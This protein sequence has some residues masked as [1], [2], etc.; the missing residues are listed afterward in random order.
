MVIDAVCFFN[1]LD[2]LELRLN[3]L[4]PV[5]DRF[6]IVEANRT[7][8][9]T[10]KPLYYA[11]NKARFAEWEEKITHI[12]CPLPDDGDGLPA[13]RRRE[14]MQRNAILQGVRDC[15]DTDVILISDCDEIPR[16]HLIPMVAP[17]VADGMVL[18]FIQK[19]YY[20]NLN[21]HA[22]ARPW[23]GTRMCRVADARAL[24]PHIIRNS[25]GQFDAHYPID[26]HVMDGG[27]HYSYLGDTAHIQNKMREFLHQ[28]LV[29]DENTTPE[30]IEA[31][32]A[33]GLD[34]W[35][36]EGEQEFTIGRADDLPYT[37]LRDLPKWTKH[38]APA[39]APVFHEDWYNGGQA[40]Y[41]GQ[42][43]RTAPEGACVEIGCWEGRSSVILAQMI[44][45]RVLHCV[46]HWRGNVD[47]DEGHES[48]VIAS[49]RD[50]LE[51]F[52]NNMERCTAGNW[53]HYV[54]SWQQFTTQLLMDYEHGDPFRIAFL[55][56]DASHDRK[57]VADCLSA[58]KPFL[59]GGAILCGDDAYDE[60]VIAG[61]RDVF[62]D[63]EVI[64]ERLWK[65]VYV[66]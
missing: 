6:V 1:E 13:I 18:A 32:I 47:E 35:G 65:V 26:R 49:E 63:A 12:I 34:I 2:L 4:A 5:V 51:T 48:A 14:M 8:K 30:A 42:L 43:A 45:P 10:L 7:H 37:I 15:A 44:N 20:F 39:W 60:R 38:F 22:A 64:G 41:V 40:L 16:S 3:E 36:R 58:I 29:T 21:T 24:S 52:V 19:L 59:V 17:Y 25:M 9:G 53:T 46:D 11:E 57:S 66:G 27:W 61:V 62:P 28:E 55:H 50:V 54:Q 23:P 33:A 56:L 31:K